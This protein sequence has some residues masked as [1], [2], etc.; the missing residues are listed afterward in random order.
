M[1][2]Q[3]SKNGGAWTDIT[4]TT[5]GAEIAV[6]AGDVL[7]FKGT[8]PTGVSLSNYCYF[9]VAD[10]ATFNTSGSVMSLIGGD[11]VALSD[12]CFCK[13]FKGCLG[14]LSAPD[15]PATTLANYCYCAMFGGCTGL[16]SA[17]ELLP[18]STLALNCYYAMFTDCTGLTSAPELP[19]TNL[20]EGLSLIH[21]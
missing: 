7:K 2:L 12:Y 15:L 10:G 11:D 19:A 6:V 16:T 4:A 13:L 8:G 14:L 1:T 5:A 3:Y 18:A 20:E 9:G 17:P 21:I